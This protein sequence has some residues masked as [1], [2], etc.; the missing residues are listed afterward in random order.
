LA[1]QLVYIWWETSTYDLYLAGG[2]RRARIWFEGNENETYRIRSAYIKQGDVTVTVCSNFDVP[3]NGRWSDWLSTTSLSL[4]DTVELWIEL[5]HP[6]Y[7][8][9]YEGTEDLVV[10]SI[11]DQGSGSSGISSPVTMTSDPAYETDPPDVFSHKA[12]NAIAVSSNGNTIIACQDAK[13]IK[14]NYDHPLY[15][16]STGK[17]F[18]S[19]DSGSTW[20]DR[21]PPDWFGYRPCVSC[22]S[23]GQKIVLTSQAIIPYTD[24]SLG[25]SH[26]FIS[27]YDGCVLI[28][29][30]GGATWADHWPGYN[31]NPGMFYSSS[32]VTIYGI[33]DIVSQFVPSGRGSS[34]HFTY[35]IKVLGA[36]NDGQIQIVLDVNYADGSINSISGTTPFTGDKWIYYY[37][38]RIHYQSVDM[39][40]DGN[41]IIA[42]VYSGEEYGYFLSTDGGATWS[43]GAI[44]IG[45][46]PVYE[47]SF[48]TCCISDDGLKKGLVSFGGMAQN[49]Y[50]ATSSSPQLL[51]LGGSILLEISGDGSTIY[52]SNTALQ[53]KISTNNLSSSS[54]VTLPAGA[55]VYAMDSIMYGKALSTSTNGATV[56]LCYVEYFGEETPPINVV[57]V[58]CDYGVTWTELIRA[59][60]YGCYYTVRVSG[61]GNT[62]VVGETSVGS[63]YDKIHVFTYPY[64]SVPDVSINPIYTIALPPETIPSLTCSASV[65]TP[66][67]IPKLTISAAGHME[68]HVYVILPS[69][70]SSAEGHIEPHVHVTLPSMYSSGSSYQTNVIINTIGLLY[71][72]RN[73]AV[74]QVDKFGFNSL[75]FLGDGESAGVNDNGIYKL[76]SGQLDATA[77]I[78]SS[79]QFGP[80]DFGIP[81]KKRVRI[82]DIGCRCSG[83]LSLTVTDEEG[84][85]FTKTGATKSNLFLPEKIR[86]F[87][88]RNVEGRYLTFTL[89]NTEGCD[90]EL[91]DIFVNLTV[92]RAI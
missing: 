60:Y 46:T 27:K 49:I 31:T 4:P 89:T 70:Y 10:S 59:D 87:G 63:T 2:Y 67:N 52:W 72:T 7:L 53:L 61:D 18:V 36:D 79:I 81:F 44:F 85:S 12:W 45:E 50:F 19:N 78:N 11:P 30:D 88:N 5:A 40:S 25:F 47:T 66:T 41:G 20:M 22:D 82:M 1:Y 24:V 9:F 32:S 21:T 68:P 34:S 91:L 56:A 43:K 92:M 65:A 26:E 16:A 28:S 17:V 83:T 54:T 29:S 73:L 37:G 76:F 71:N 8:P 58:S 80:T 74:T 84:R 62:V 90:F 3:R 51:E 33:N 15:C 6:S 35:P 77:Q 75:G 42:C 13:I 55:M 39:T 14:D 23:T 57:A 69:M 86:I 38:S 48:L 64:S